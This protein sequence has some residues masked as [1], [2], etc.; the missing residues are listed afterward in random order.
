MATLVVG[1][2]FD[3]VW[4]VLMFVVLGA[5]SSAVFTITSLRSV[6]SF[7]QSVL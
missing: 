7:L 2:V 3:W 5:A 4:E 1:Q 6:E